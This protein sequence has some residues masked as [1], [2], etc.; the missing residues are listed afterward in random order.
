M[1]NSAQIVQWLCSDCGS[2]N[3]SSQLGCNMC[4]NIRPNRN[5][6]MARV[7]SSSFMNEGNDNVQNNVNNVAFHGDV[8]L[9]NYFP[10]VN[11]EDDNSDGSE[12]RDNYK[13]ARSFLYSFVMT[14]CGVAIWTSSIVM[15]LAATFFV[16]VFVKA[17]ILN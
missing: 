3:P 12:N 7:L 8:H 5:R 10:T 11:D 1:K 16:T 17:F 15:G 6:D 13:P 14:A 2:R 9:D 4:G